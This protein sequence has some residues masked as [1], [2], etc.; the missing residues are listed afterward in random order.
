[1]TRTKAE[2]ES[3]PK[4]FWVEAVAYTACYSNRFLTKAYMTSQKHG[5]ASGPCRAHT[6]TLRVFFYASI[7]K[8][9]ERSLVIMV[10]SACL[11]A[12]ARISSFHEGDPE[13]GIVE[14]NI[15]K[16]NLRRT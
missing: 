14:Q 11:F 16:A 15:K 12:I 10:K 7:L 8:A 2:I 3:I 1:M 4:P 13:H 6:Y 5:A 9:K